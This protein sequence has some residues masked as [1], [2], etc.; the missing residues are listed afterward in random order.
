MESQ[1]QKRYRRTKADIAEDIRKAAVD[2]ILEKG[3]SGSLVTE[4]IKKAK[5]ILASMDAE[6][7]AEGK[8]QPVVYM[9][10]SKNFYEMRDS[11]ELVLTPNTQRLSDSDYQEIAE[12]YK[13]LPTMGDDE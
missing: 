11:Q 8:I 2:Q 3:F 4:I 13:Q 10:R 12:K 9:F 5:Q 7:A 1:P 6:L